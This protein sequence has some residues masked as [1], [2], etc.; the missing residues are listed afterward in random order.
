LKLKLASA[1]VL[2]WLAQSAA[3]AQSSDVLG[4]HNLTPGS[5]SQVTAR[6]AAGCT[7]CHAPHSGIGGNTPLWNQQ[8][9]KA[10]Y[11]PYTSTS[12]HQRGNTQP[13]LGQS[14]SLCLSCHD[15]TVA[16]GQTQAYGKLQTQ[17]SMK[18]ADVLGRNLSS[19]HPFSMVTPMKDSASLAASLVAQ[20]KTA[21]PSGAVKLIN[22]NVEC[23]SC[24]NPH[25]QAKDKVAQNFLVR[26]SSG[27]QMCLACHDPKRVSQGKVNLLAGWTGSIHATATN[28]A[29][30]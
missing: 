30:G 24:H 14:S 21:D 13:P 17:G 23:T 16:I 3:N 28:E 11:T 25:V 22:G 6:G 2:V 8:L 18:N 15:G 27:G 10:T 26:D 5:G 12:Y 19:S 7:F 20:K 4:Q 29:A 1:L 9:S